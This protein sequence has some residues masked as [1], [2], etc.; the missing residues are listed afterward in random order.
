ML[1]EL[2]KSEF[3]KVLPLFRDYLQ[4]PMMHAV[5]EGKSGGQ[6][7]VDDAYCPAAAFVWTGTECAY[8]AGGAQS[9]GFLQALYQMVV[10]EIIPVAQADGREYLSLFSFPE[11]YAPKLEELFSDQA[12]LRT[13][14]STFAFD[15]AAFY[16][17]HRD[18]SSLPGT[19]LTLKRLGAEELVVPENAYLTG[20]IKAY[21]GTIE[22]FLARGSGYCV[23]D[24]GSLVS[25]CYVQAYGHSSQTID[26][27]TAPSHRR[28]GLGILVSEAV[29]RT[30]LEEG[31]TPF[32]I[33]DKANTPS[34]RLAERLGFR[35]TGDIFL[36][37]IPFAPYTFYLGLAEHFFLPQGE[38]RQAAEAY[39]RAF[40]VQQGEAEDYYHASVAWGRAGEAGRSQEYLQKAIDSGWEAR[41]TDVESAD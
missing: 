25:W 21:W 26:I 20:E 33:C 1:H 39:D 38:Y 27:W 40:S 31:Y 24:G 22:R 17:R 7:F 19:A 10:E 2:E 13:P 32:W 4:D 41:G 30:S 16:E 12:P 35:Y 11:S 6:V 15:E 8:L 14:L 3:R 34:R 28:Q 37:D 36:V 9:A 18:S 23:L 29:I 5:I